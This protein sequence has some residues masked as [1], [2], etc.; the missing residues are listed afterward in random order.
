MKKNKILDKIKTGEVKMK[1]RWK[2]EAVKWSEMGLWIAMMGLG[3]VGAMGMGYF[4]MVY[5]LV[6]LAEFG[7]LGWQILYE[8]FPYILGAMSIFG[9]IVGV[10]VMMNIGNNYK[11]SWQKNIMLMSLIIFLLT[12][13]G[14]F[15]RP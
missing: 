4:L 2:F 7:D 8:D 6:E 11:R 13:V 9:L 10:I 15:L 14:L 5:N 12:I 3:V 1:P